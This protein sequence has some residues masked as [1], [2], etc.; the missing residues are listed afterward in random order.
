MIPVDRYKLGNSLEIST[1]LNTINTKTNLFFIL[2]PVFSNPS[3]SSITQIQIPWYL[4]AIQTCKNIIK[5]SFV[6]ETLHFLNS[7]SHFSVC[8]EVKYILFFFW[9]IAHNTSSP[10]LYNMLLFCQAY[11]TTITIVG[12]VSL[13]KSLWPLLHLHT[14]TNT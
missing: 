1:F 14:L 6:L 4:R 7:W 3:Y 9:P 13:T 5:G 11:H 10:W 8:F 2:M 12:V